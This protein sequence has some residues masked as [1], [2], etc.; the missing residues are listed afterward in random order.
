MTDS[1][2]VVWPPAPIRTERLVLRESEARDR[3]TFVE[4]LGSAEVNTYLGGPKSPDTLDGLPETP[5]RRPGVLVVEAGGEMIGTV[6]LE[7][8]NL[9]PADR[10]R[11]EH[12]EADLG[13]LFLPKAWGHGY[14]AEPLPTVD[15]AGR[16]TGPFRSCLA[17]PQ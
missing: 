12:G 4:L 9:G 14:A 10:V 13:Y 1:A 11:P 2:P 6:M 7:R 15:D 17:T 8:R 5:G 3:Q 16:A